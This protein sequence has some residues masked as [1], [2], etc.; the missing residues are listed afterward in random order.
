MDLLILGLSV[1][2]VAWSLANE[3]GPAD[4]FFKMRNVLRPRLGEGV[5]CPVCVGMWVAFVLFAVYYFFGT[6]PLLPFA[7][8]GAST[9]LVLYLAK[10]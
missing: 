5:D 10:R 4:L 2:S 6:L 7:A 3:D 9:F 1:F 8:H